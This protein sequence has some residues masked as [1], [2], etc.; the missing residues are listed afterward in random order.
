MRLVVST[1]NDTVMI[2]IN[3]QAY[4]ISKDDYCVG[5][6]MRS[7]HYCCCVCSVVVVPSFTTTIIIL[8]VDHLLLVSA[9]H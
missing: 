5:V 6:I 1:P 9:G 2:L 8:D 7:A 3:R 4:S